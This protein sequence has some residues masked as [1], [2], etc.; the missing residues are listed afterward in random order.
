MN[1]DELFKKLHDVDA[2]VRSHGGV[3]RDVDARVR[4]H[5]KRGGGGVLS[6]WLP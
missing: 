6:C 5:G 3:L 4:S 1:E 2:R